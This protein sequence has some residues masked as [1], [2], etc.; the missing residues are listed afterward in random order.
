MHGIDI[1]STFCS[2]SFFPIFII[3]PEFRWAHSPSALLRCKRTKH[4]KILN[5]IGFLVSLLRGVSIAKLLCEPDF[6]RKSFCR[7]QFKN[8]VDFF[9]WKWFFINTI[10]VIRTVPDNKSRIC[11]FPSLFEE[12]GRVLPM[13]IGRTRSEWEK[14]TKYLIFHFF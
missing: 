4:K 1:Q 2:F 11:L 3:Q 13:A 6:N 14:K 5:G 10:K 8:L 9:F 7:V 12:R